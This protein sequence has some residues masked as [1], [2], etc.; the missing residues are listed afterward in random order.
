MNDVANYKRDYTPHVSR[1]Q[2]RMTARPYRHLCARMSGLARPCRMSVVGGWWV[3][4]SV[5]VSVFLCRCKGLCP[6]FR[7]G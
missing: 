2:T 1:P 5:Q 7:G 3:L 4:V 6:P